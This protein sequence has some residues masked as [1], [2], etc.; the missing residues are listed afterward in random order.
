DPVR[1]RILRIL[2]GGERPVS[3]IASLVGQSP[4]SV[5]HHLALLRVAGL[6]ISRRAGKLNDYRLSGRSDPLLRAIEALITGDSAP[7]TP[8]EPAPRAGE[9]ELVFQSTKA[10]EADIERLPGKEGERFM[11][12]TNLRCRLLP[13]DRQ[14]LGADWSRPYV[15]RLSQGLESTLYVMR[16]GGQRRAILTLDDDPIFGRTVVTLLRLVPRREAD[17]AYRDVASRLYAGI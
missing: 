17:E 15:A 2:S 10:F 16:V 11:E 6:I 4:P 5:S 9:A 1:L 13:T 14:T 3:E 7:Q 12:R 8:V